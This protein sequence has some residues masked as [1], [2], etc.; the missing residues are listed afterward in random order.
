MIRCPVEAAAITKIVRPWAAKRLCQLPGHEHLCQG[1]VIVEITATLPSQS[2]SSAP[3]AA[4]LELDLHVCSLAEE[5]NGSPCIGRQPVGARTCSGECAD[6]DVERP[7]RSKRPFDA[8]DAPLT[9]G[10][11]VPGKRSVHCQRRRLDLA[12]GSGRSRRDEVNGDDVD[13]RVS[14]IYLQEREKAPLEIA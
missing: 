7:Q 9:S 2:Q 1:A 4:L 11:E 6:H 12:A 14:E 13:G 8:D 5:T 3:T 10:C